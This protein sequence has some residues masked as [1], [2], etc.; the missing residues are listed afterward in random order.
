MR[1]R[2]VGEEREGR[3]VGG[4]GMVVVG[5]GVGVGVP[6]ILEWCCG[7]KRFSMTRGRQCRPKGR[8]DRRAAKKRGLDFN[9]VELDDGKINLIGRHGT[10]GQS[11]RLRHSYSIVVHYQHIRHCFKVILRKRPYIAKDVARLLPILTPLNILIRPKP[12]NHPCPCPNS[13]LAMAATQ[14]SIARSHCVQGCAMPSLH[15]AAQVA[16][17]PGW[18]VS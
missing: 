15:V 2:W 18:R 6:G 8:L 10:R 16:Y 1:E 5:I 7:S 11:A 3:I 9:V 14:P 4:G 17:E 12:S 13:N